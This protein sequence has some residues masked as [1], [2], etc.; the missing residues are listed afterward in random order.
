MRSKLLLESFVKISE[1]FSFLS[2]TKQAEELSNI[3]EEQSTLT[4]DKE[5]ISGKR[6]LQLKKEAEERHEINLRMGV[7]NALAVYVGYKDFS[8][9]EKEQKKGELT[10]KDKSS[11][12]FRAHKTTLLVSIGLLLIFLIFESVTKRKWMVWKKDHYEQIDFNENDYSTGKLKLY[13][14]TECDAFFKIQPDC[15]TVFFTQDGK[16]LIW[17]GKNKNR[18]YEFFSTR[19]NHPETDKPLKPITHYMVEKY[20]C[21]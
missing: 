6:L 16:S 10:F 8:T 7:A 5:I 4:G 12:F 20:I 3:I 13:K 9:Y 1:Q 17:Y 14:S 15:N 2:K 19:G 21:P 18:E 11:N